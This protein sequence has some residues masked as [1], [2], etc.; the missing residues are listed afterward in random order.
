MWVGGQ[1]TFFGVKVSGS[2]DFGLQ[3][4]QSFQKHTV[5]ASLFQPMYTISFADEAMAV[6]EDFLHRAVT[7]A[8]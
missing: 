2:A 7:N 5:Y 1:G 6:P 4:N 3:R 8:E